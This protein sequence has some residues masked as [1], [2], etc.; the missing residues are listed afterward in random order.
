ML[1]CAGPPS[2]QTRVRALLPIPVTQVPVTWQAGDFLSE[3]EA[4]DV[5]L[6]IFI[7]KADYVKWL[8]P[9]ADS[10]APSSEVQPPLREFPDVFFF[11]TSTRSTC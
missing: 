8:C 6:L 4:L 9:M 7:S 2:A 3:S 5:S 11:E 10:P 1:S